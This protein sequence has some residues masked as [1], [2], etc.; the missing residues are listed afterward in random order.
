MPQLLKLTDIAI[1]GGTQSRDVMDWDH[2]NEL[3][4]DIESLH[5]SPVMVMWD[6]KAQKHWLYDGFHRYEAHKKAGKNEIMAQIR[7]GSRRDAVIASLSANK[8]HGLKRK[9]ADKRKCV[10]TCLTDPEWRLW[11]NTLIAEVCDVSEGLVRNIRSE[12]SDDAQKGNSAFVRTNAPTPE[13]PPALREEAE[14]ITAAGGDPRVRSNQHGLQITDASSRKNGKKGK[15]SDQPP[16]ASPPPLTEADAQAILEQDPWYGFNQ[17]IEAHISA[18]KSIAIQMAK[19]MGYD[20]ESKQLRERFANGYSYAGTVGQ[21]NQ[22]IR[23]LNDGMPA[24]PSDKA[25][26]FLTARQAEIKSKTTKRAA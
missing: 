24:E 3:V 21:I 20:S 22:L 10:M 4:E 9:P 17:K 26:G 18:L 11:A 13:L 12:Q 23:T 25:P 14:R 8:Q 7:H 19:D 16:Y 1:D 2:V 5:K 6:G 15:D